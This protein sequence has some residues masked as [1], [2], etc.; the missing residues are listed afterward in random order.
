[1]PGQLGDDGGTRAPR[2]SPP[3][4]RRH[5]GPGLRHVIRGPRDDHY[6]ELGYSLNRSSLRAWSIARAGRHYPRSTGEFQAWFGTDADC[7]DYLDWLRWPGGFACPSCGHAG[8]WRLGDGRY[9]CAG[10]K[11]RTSVTAGTI[12]DR[13]R[14]PL[15]VWF[16]AC[17]LFAT[18]KDG[19]SAQSLHRSL[20][21]G[22]YPTAWAMLHR[23]RSVLVRPGRDRLAG[24][25]EVDETFIGGQEPGLRGG[26]AR[27]KKVLTGIAVEVGTPKGIGRCRMAVLD[28]ASAESLNPFVTGAVEPGSTVITDGWQGYSGLDG[29]RLHPRAP[30]PAGRPRPRR[31]PRRAAARSAPRRF[32]GQAVAAGHPPGLGGPGRTC[33][34]TSMSSP[35]GSI[36]AAREAAAWSSTGCWS[37]PPGM[38]RF[39][40]ATSWPANSRTQFPQHGAGAIRQAWTV[41]RRTGPGGPASSSCSYRSHS[42]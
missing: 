31:G 42:G 36:G 26:R 39:A 30:Q 17:W 15:T 34:P 13:T 18:Q 29:P 24:T 4:R 14:T 21:I 25:V 9:E 10:C 8:G 3:D 41:Q 19:I 12:F 37:W 6:P 7:L 40:S 20:E 1:M 32:P 33:P 2:C 27:G 28:D 22:S 35:S 23:L 38:I 16:H 5:V 11:R